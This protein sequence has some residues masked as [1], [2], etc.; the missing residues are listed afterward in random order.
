MTD[1]IN[2]T[3]APPRILIVVEGGIVQSVVS[4]APIK[5]LIK[6]FDTI[7]A[8]PACRDIDM[9]GFTDQDLLCPTETEFMQQVL[10]DIPEMEPR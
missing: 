2:T 1:T 3:S 6:D 7:D 4:D 10:A 9:H 8:D 5:I